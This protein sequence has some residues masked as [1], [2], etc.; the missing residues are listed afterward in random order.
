MSVISCNEIGTGRGGELDYAQGRRW[1]RRFQVITDSDLDG[2]AT[3][4]LCPFLPQVGSI[5]LT[6]GES[7]SFAFLRSLTPEQDPNDARVWTVT[8][9]YQTEDAGKGGGSGSPG[10][11]GASPQN[12]PENPL[13]RPVEWRASYAKARKTV[14]TDKD[15]KD[16]KNSAG[17]YFSPGYERDIIMAMFSATK[18]YASVTFADTLNYYGKINSDTWHGLDAKTV[19]IDNIEMQSMYENGTSY[20]RLTWSFLYDPDKW[21]PTK[22]LD[23]GAYYL[24]ATS[25]KP[26]YGVDPRINA[27]LPEVLLDGSG[28]WLNNGASG[29]AVAVYNLFRFHD[30]IAFSTIGL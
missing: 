18:N 28:G 6:D 23:R 26:A 29:P 2:P 7:D 17:Q 21:N 12:R 5:Y 30:E 3:V 24:D 25:G 11:G 20:V 10:Q 4:V 1:T 8:A 14:L 19:K 27:I 22:I 15:G 13:D 16:V 9:T